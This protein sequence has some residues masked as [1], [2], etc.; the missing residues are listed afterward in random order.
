MKI[1]IDCGHTLSGDDYGA[2]GIKAESVLTREVGT[3]VINKLKALDHSVINCTIDTCN[4]LEKS[5]AYRVNQANN[6]NVDLFISIHFNAYNGQV[7]GTE[8]LTWGAEQLPEATRVLNNLVGLGYA[9]R[10]IKDGSNLYVIRNTKSKAMLIECCFCDNKEDMNKY[11]AEKIANAIVEGI[12]GKST[13]NNSNI[14]WY[15]LDGKTGIVTAKD[16]LN[17]REGKS[18]NSRILETLSYGRKIRLYRK[19]DNW[20]HIYHSEHGGYAHA[21]YID[22][23]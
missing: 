17:V 9:N 22:I 23:L 8:I 11:D 5:L 15:F 10:G 16:G 12:A 18:T 19:E 21:E 14:N 4:S 1:G 2:V 3:R 20:I 7:H 13:S 6:N